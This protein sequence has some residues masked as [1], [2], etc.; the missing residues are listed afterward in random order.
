LSSSS[1]KPAPPA[2]AA[3]ERAQVIAS[4]APIIRPTHRTGNCIQSSLDGVAPHPAAVTVRYV[5]VQIGPEIDG[6]HRLLRDVSATHGQ[7]QSN[8]I[9]MNARSF[10]P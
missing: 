1:P 9:I 5:S 4:T 8:S 10:R 7:V 2:H 6:R 3:I